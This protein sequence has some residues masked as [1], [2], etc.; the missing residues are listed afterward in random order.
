MAT[1]EKPKIV[2]DEVKSFLNELPIQE[3]VEL[4]ADIIIDQLLKD[5]YEN[6]EDQYGSKGIRDNS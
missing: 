1:Y 3:Q 2:N 4:F 6:A 5:I